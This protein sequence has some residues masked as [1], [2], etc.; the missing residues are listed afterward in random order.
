MNKHLKRILI[1]LLVLVLFLGGL[2]FGYT[3]VYYHATK[4]V[5]S[6]QT[7]EIKNGFALESDESKIGFIFYPGGKVETE[8]YLPLLEKLQE[9]GI[10]CYLVDMPFRLA[11]FGADRAEDII[12]AHPEIERW[13]IGGHSLGGAFASNFASKNQ[14]KID[15]LVLLGAYVYGNFPVEKSITIYGGNDGVLNRDKITYTENVNVIDG[16]NHAQ[17]GNYG[18]QKGDGEASITAEEQQ[19]KTAKLI[20]EFINE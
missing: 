14:D 18:E 11:F 19:T 17:F 8:A 10:S 7:A 13:Y 3:S 20:L 2:F 4:E 9:Q 15:G 6:I 5:N 16:G 12:N 1:S